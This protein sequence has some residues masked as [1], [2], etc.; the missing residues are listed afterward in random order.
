MARPS[1]FL[2]T[3]LSGHRPVSG[4]E[5]CAQEEPGMARQGVASQGGVQGW[6]RQ[7]GQ[8]AAQAAG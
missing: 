1:S 2:G 5:S 8:W 3:W 7:H 4:S 6:L